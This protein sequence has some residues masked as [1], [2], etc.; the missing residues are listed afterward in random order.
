MNAPILLVVVSNWFPTTFSLAHGLARARTLIPTDVAVAPVFRM[1][2][3]MI[4]T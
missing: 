3:P 4:F 1:V 2:L